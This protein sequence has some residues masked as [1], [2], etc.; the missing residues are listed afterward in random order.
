[1]QKIENLNIRP[2]SQ[3]IYLKYSVNNSKLLKFKINREI[4]KRLKKDY[5]LNKTQAKMLIAFE[6]HTIEDGLIDSKNYAFVGEHSL[7]NILDIIYSKLVFVNYDDEETYKEE[8]DNLSL[9]ELALVNY[10]SAKLAKGYKKRI[11]TLLNR[12]SDGEV[13]IYDT[14]EESINLQKFHYYL[15]E[16]SKNHFLNQPYFVSKKQ[17]LRQFKKEQEFMLTYNK[18]LLSQEVI[19]EINIIKNNQETLKLY[20]KVAKRK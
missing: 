8:L 5:Q 13:S 9:S 10:I 11:N 20:Q 4:N 16:N 7:S 19:G 15:A 18:G 3:L 12:L 14:L 1:M 17:A 2:I 6:R